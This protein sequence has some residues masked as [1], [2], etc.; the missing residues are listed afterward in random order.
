MAEGALAR[1]HPHAQ[2]SVAVTGVAGPGSDSQAK[3]AGLVHVAAAQ[4]GKGIVHARRDFGDIGRDRVRQA[5]VELALDV[6]L[7][8]LAEG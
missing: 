7:R 3:P 1:A 2:V 8:R 6:V 5:T 4:R